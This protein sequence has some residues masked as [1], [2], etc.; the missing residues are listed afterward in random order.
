MTHDPFTLSCLIPA[1]NEGPRIAQ[2]LAAV[3]NH[4]LIDEV[5]VIDDGSSDDTA[6]IA[7][8]FGVR[9]LTQ[10]PN[11]GKTRAVV[12]GIAAAR[13]SHLLLL[14]ADLL[15]LTPDALTA[16]IEPVRS[17]AVQATISLRGNA[18]APW[19]LIGL[20]YISG[21]RVLPR[22]ILAAQ[23]QALT[24][25]PRFG[26]EVFMNRL[27]LHHRL[28]LRVVRWPE[29]ASPMKH[30][31]RGWRAG[32]SA[33]LRMMADIFATIPPQEAL[34]QILQMRAASSELRP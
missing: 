5:I 18:P 28:R 30:S 21:E 23:L 29:V 14:D 1:Y 19:R 22:H 31:K 24:E 34:R 27:W 32:I 13:G 17:G 33:D 9:V 25:L 10:S 3:V 6:K 20:D 7:A 15:G 16:L 26:L 11:G 8:G 2:V 4:P 12:A